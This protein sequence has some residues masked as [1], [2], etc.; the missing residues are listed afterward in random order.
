MAGRHNIEDNLMRV[1]EHIEEYKKQIE[2]FT[3]NIIA[4]QGAVQALERLAKEEESKVDSDTQAE[5][6]TE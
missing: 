4:L 6:N 3:R 5:E 2:S 1:K